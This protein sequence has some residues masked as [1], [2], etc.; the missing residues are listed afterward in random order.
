M[1]KL[2]GDNVYGIKGFNGYSNHASESY[3]K[4]PMIASASNI[5]GIEMTMTSIVE[6]PYNV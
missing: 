6:E 2:T 1:S 5:D 4:G 3:I